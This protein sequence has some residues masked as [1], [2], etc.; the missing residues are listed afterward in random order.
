MIILT[1]TSKTMRPAAKKMQQLRQPQL[2][3]KAKILD[4]Q[5]K[6]LSVNEI[7]KLMKVSSKLAKQAQMLI[8][9]WTPDSGSQ[10][11]AIDSFLGDIY[12]GMQVQ[13]WTLDDRKYA[14]QH[15]IIL[16]G[17]YGLVRPLDGICPYRYEMGYKYPSSDYPNLYGFWGGD[18]A[19]FIPAEV[20]IVNLTAVEYSKVLTPHINL[21]R[22]VMPK[23]LTISPK[24]KKPEF[25]TVHTK[26]ARGA[27]ARWIIR[28]RIDNIE[29][30]NDFSELNYVYNPELSTKGVP[31]YVC[32][33]F[34][35]LGLSVRLTKALS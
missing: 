20:P 9:E 19:G 24:T 15:M 26:I 5:L 13:S 8:S 21:D 1:H 18:V 25:V 4:A 28:E 22:F 23:F 11:A 30:F 3:D 14:D 17:L 16:S 7:Q 35:G 2:I 33:Q 10:R 27:F 6:L 34:G 12:S 32:Q 31:V 29:K